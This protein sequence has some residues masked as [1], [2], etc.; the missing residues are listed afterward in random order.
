MIIAFSVQPTGEPSDPE[1]VRDLAEGSDAASVHDAVAAAVQ[2]VR[3]SGLPN[4][5]S[6]MF[7][8]IVDLGH[9]S[10]IRPAGI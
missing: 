9:G 1:V 7:T 3:D 2:V 4:R 6:S 10:F 5:T 8:S